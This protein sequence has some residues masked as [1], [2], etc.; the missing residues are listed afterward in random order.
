LEAASPRHHHH[1]FHRQK[2]ADAHQLLNLERKSLEALSNS[3]V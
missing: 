1:H 2:A 3:N